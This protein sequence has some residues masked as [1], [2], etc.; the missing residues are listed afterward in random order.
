[1][2]LKQMTLGDLVKFEEITGISLIDG[3]AALKLETITEM[4]ALMAYDK[5]GKY[6][7]RSVIEKLVTTENMQEVVDRVEFL[8][9]PEEDGED[10]PKNE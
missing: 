6:V 3:S 9:K 4:L 8:L 2:T 1:M 7:P 10:D 5:D